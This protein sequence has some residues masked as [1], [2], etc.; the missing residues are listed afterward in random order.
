MKPISW[1]SPGPPTLSA[2]SARST[3]E[4]HSDHQLRERPSPGR[5]RHPRRNCHGSRS[6]RH[7]RSPASAPQFSASCVRGDASAMTDLE[8]ARMA[9]GLISLSFLP[10]F[11]RLP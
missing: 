10:S 1:T 2:R 7:C 5:G 3:Y 6:F 9:A 4:H 11:R 8:C